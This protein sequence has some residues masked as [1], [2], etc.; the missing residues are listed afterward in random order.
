M[1]L[2]HFRKKILSLSPVSMKRDS[3]SVAF[4]GY[5]ELWSLKHSITLANA[6]ACGTFRR[7]L[8]Q[9]LFLNA[10]RIADWPIPSPKSLLMFANSSFVNTEFFIFRLIFY[11]QIQNLYNSLSSK[12]LLF[13]AK[14]YLCSV[15]NIKCPQKIYSKI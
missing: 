10:L 6:F 13:L 4:Q 11:L 3:F 5:A 2:Y 7:F 1:W 15:K 12:T 9:K 14:E 8:G